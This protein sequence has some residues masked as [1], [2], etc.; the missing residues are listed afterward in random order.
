MYKHIFLSSPRDI[1]LKGDGGNRERFKQ[2]VIQK[3]KALYN[4]QYYNPGVPLGGSGIGTAKSWN[5]KE[6][7]NMISLCSGVVL[8]GFRYWSD[9]IQ[10]GGN[11]EKKFLPTEYCHYE[12]AI[13]RDYNI[14]VFPLL[15]KGV[16]QRIMFASHDADEIF[17]FPENADDTW[18]EKSDFNIFLERWSR[19]KVEK[20][21]DLFLGYSTK[22]EAQAKE[23]R[24][25]LENTYNEIKILDWKNFNPGGYILDRIR[26]AS[27]TCTGAILLLTA[28]ELMMKEN[29]P[30]ATKI[31][32]PR[33]NLLFE[34][35]Y[36]LH[37]KGQE[38]VLLIIDPD[39]KIP[40]DMGGLI[41]APLPKKENMS[42]IHENLE[43]FLNKII[44]N[45][46]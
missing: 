13:A 25:F 10:L 39:T 40:A 27:E 9:C 1:Y 19:E 15:E 28:D 16:E 37:A 33:D 35:G 42:D 24:S 44:I 17:E 21:Y 22:V 36:F 29:D 34:A 38:R 23:I 6:A 4:L 30:L 11:G 26:K 3:I 14:P 18:L 43:N 2:G 8:I 5:Y 20:R 31:T 7:K 32:I 46:A 12:G 41:Y 45:P